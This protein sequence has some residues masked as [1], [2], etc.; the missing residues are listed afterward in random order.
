MTH[1]PDKF[2]LDSIASDSTGAPRMIK[3]IGS[4]VWLDGSDPR[5]HDFLSHVRGLM[6]LRDVQQLDQFVQ[7]MNTSRLAHSV[8]VAWYSYLVCR[9]F[10][11]D[12]PSAARAGILHDLYLYDWRTQ[13]QPEGY[14]AK[15]HPIVA[16]R[17]ARKNVVLNPIEADCIVKHMWPLTLTPPVYGESFLLSCMDKW[18]TTLEVGH[19]FFWQKIGRGRFW[20]VLI[21]GDCY[22]LT[23]PDV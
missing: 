16:L 21:L 20:R 11:L 22:K 9:F 2:P 8:N 15:A 3:A 14:H 4:C 19:Q 10:R 1:T 12:A 17:T 18:A 7:H 13:K 5:A 6:A 23:R